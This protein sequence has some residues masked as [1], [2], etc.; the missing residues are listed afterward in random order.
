MKM[1]KISSIALLIYCLCFSALTFAQDSNNK[2]TFVLTK[3]FKPEGANAVEAQINISAGVLKVKADT[4]QLMDAKF[5]YTQ[6][7]FKPEISY[8]VQA[9][10]GMLV[11][12]QQKEDNLNMKDEDRNEWNIRLNNSIPMDLNLTIGAGQG[13]VDLSKMKLSKVKIEGGAGEF[14]INLAHT[15][16]PK[17]KISAGVGA[18][19][20]DLTGKWTNDL[21]ADINGGIGDITLKLPKKTG[22]RVSINGLGS[23]EGSGFKKQ[24]KYY[25]NEAYEKE[26]N[27][28]EIDINGGLG[29]VKLE[30]GE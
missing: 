30:L 27:K 23:V 16:V 20:L 26:G 2:D 29:S 14:K 25:V 28:L 22:V 13:L 18:L 4:D 19:S 17:L 15:S 6:E 10:K 12:K 8:N 3:S 24:G 7:K 11:V 5:T 1:H 21:D 9:G